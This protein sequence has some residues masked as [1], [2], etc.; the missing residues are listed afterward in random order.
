MAR[1][2]L[3][4]ASEGL[5][6][7][8]YDPISIS[9]LDFNRLY[10]SRV[11]ECV[12]SDHFTDI[13]GSGEMQLAPQVFPPFGKLNFRTAAFFVPEHQI[14]SAS[15]AW[16]NNQTMYKGRSFKLPTFKPYDVLNGFIAAH[17]G[18]RTLVKTIKESDPHDPD[19]DFPQIYEYDFI[20]ITNN[21][22][23]L[24]FD[25]YKLNASGYRYYSFF[26]QLGYDFVSPPALFDASL[27]S[28]VA[29]RYAYCKSFCDYSRSALPLL[30]YAKVYADYFIPG[31]FFNGSNIVKLLQSVHDIA[32]MTVG[33]TPWFTAST[34]VV[35]P[36]ACQY[37]YN[38]KTP[39]SQDMYTSAWNSPNSP[40]GTI[41]SDYGVG[42]N[43]GIISPYVDQNPYANCIVTNS[44]LLL[45]SL[46]IFS[47]SHTNYGLK[48]SVKARLT[49]KSALVGDDL[50]IK[51]RV[52]Q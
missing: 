39:V 42:N 30:A 20:A 48:S 6:H 51:V 7:H 49:G 19:T 44:D 25:F 38:C 21:M 16:H 31:Q 13:S 28:G 50:V 5:Y 15:E 37:I 14:F 17:N 34:G 2:F 32:D 33:G 47:R 9:S 43:G 22:S 3:N 46:L 35:S 11:I 36:E 52:D 41:P 45:F 12:P 10:T 27:P 4:P 29:N 40:L 26:K 24:Q 23:T 18:M 8:S 1:L